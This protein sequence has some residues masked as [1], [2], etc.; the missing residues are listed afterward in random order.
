M[1]PVGQVLLFAGMLLGLAVIPFGLP[2]TIIILVC[3]LIYAVMTDFSAGIGVAFFVVLCVFTLLAET[4]DN[5]LTAIG[6]RRFG[7]SSSSMWLSL[8]GGLAGAIIIGG[9]LAL[10]VGPL[11]PVVGGFAGA[12]LIVFLSERAR[13]KDTREALRAGWGTFLGR[14]AGIVLKF[15][16]AIAMIVAVAAS[17]LH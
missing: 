2:G 11:G 13:G 10:V 9:P 1:E 7:A 15:V 4:A 8:L 5:W 16:I 3:V 17:I 6:A 14:M 12:F